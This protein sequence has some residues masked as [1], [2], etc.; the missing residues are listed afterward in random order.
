MD[1]ENT[2][3]HE[4]VL[5]TVKTYP[6]LSEKYG[7][8]VCTAGVR[9]DGSW[10]RLYPTPFRLLEE[11]K[12]YVKY[13]WIELS[14]RRNSQ[15][16]RVESFRPVG[17]DIVCGEKI[18][19]WSDRRT[20]LE[21]GHIYTNRDELKEKA[22]SQKI[23]LATFKPTK[24]I[25]FRCYPAKNLP[26]NEKIERTTAVLR[27]PTLFDSE[28]VA[29]RRKFLQPVRQIPYVFKYI[30]EDDEGN[31]EKLSV[32]DWELG[33]LFSQY[34]NDE[35]AKKKVIEKYK[36]FIETKDLL[37]FLG[38]TKRHHNV[39][40]NPFIIIGVFYPPKIKEKQPT[41]F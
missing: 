29:E 31:E 23:S 37:F 6:S 8:L 34:E 27:Q 7:E 20:I 10:I 12:R 28:E 19:A 14:V 4:R 26:S 41:L 1:S 5:V 15:D 18:E 36:G 32:T 11:Y 22:R 33:A 24:I 35:V 39:S 40:R 13:Q 38:T 21:R 30:F 9:E 16:F 17:G 25:D 3:I 2:V